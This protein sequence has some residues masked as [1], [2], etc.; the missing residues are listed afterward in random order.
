MLAGAVHAARAS[1]PKAPVLS[2][3]PS[4]PVEGGPEKLLAECYYTGV[5]SGWRSGRRE[6]AGDLLLYRPQILLTLVR[7][8]PNGTQALVDTSRI[9]HLIFVGKIPD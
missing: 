7:M 3:P 6:N 5:H 1:I 9:Q 8:R 4:V 2:G